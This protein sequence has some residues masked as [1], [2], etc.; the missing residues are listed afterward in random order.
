MTDIPAEHINAIVRRVMD[1]DAD[2]RAH[3]P[4]PSGQNGQVKLQDSLLRTCNDRGT[5]QEIFDRLRWGGQLVY[6]DPDRDHAEQFSA[7]LGHSG[8]EVTLGP[9]YMA[10]GALRMFMPFAAAKTYYFVA[11]KV[12][13]V[14]P[15]KI[16]DRF[17]YYV[18]LGRMRRNEPYVVIKEVPTQEMVMARLKAKWPDLPDETIE[19]RARK[20]CDKIFPTFLTREAA[21]LKAMQQRLPEE[22]RGR[23]PRLLEVESDKRGFARRLFLEW[24]RNGGEPLSQL[25]FARQSA[26]I[27]RVLHDKVGIMHL[28]LRLDNF[29]ITPKGVGLVDFGSAVRVDENLKANPLLSNLYEELMRTSQIQRMLFS[30]TRTGE[31]TSEAISRGLH[32]V[33]KAVDYFYLAVQIN[34][35]HSNPE[36]KDLV[37]YDRHSAEARMLVQLTEQILR[38][39][40]PT[41]PRFGSAADILRGIEEI[42]RSLETAAQ[43]AAPAAI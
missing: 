35:P 14:P 29:V 25:E 13:L 28:D 22:Y 38:P 16:T 8:F 21:T 10:H 19:K 42:Q 31:V 3:P 2:L 18:Y 34:S 15:G 12:E 6:I 11:R 32:R 7:E 4:G 20:F 26:E 39:K 23:L 40:D 37:R 9:T 27:L 17:T 33:D 41:K 43:T 5:A 30:M 1:S 24:L 36:L